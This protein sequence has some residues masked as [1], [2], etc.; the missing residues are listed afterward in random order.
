MIQFHNLLKKNNGK[1]ILPAEKNEG[2]VQ[3][4][5]QNNV[6]IIV[7]KFIEVQIIQ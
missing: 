6:M 2:L 4:R 5:L 3:L 7:H 1:R